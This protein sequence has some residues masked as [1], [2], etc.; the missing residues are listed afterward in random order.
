LHGHTDPNP[1]PK[2]VGGGGGRRV[3]GGGAKKRGARGAKLSYPRRSRADRLKRTGWIGNT[4]SVKDKGGSGKAT[5]GS[6]GLE[7]PAPGKGKH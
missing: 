3:G 4:K 1:P 5:E 2:T 7:R 6:A